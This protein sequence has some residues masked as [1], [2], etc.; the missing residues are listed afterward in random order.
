MKNSILLLLALF[1]VACGSPFE[2]PTF[3]TNGGIVRSN[4][5]EKFK[6]FVSN[7]IEVKSFDTTGIPGA[8]FEPLIVGISDYWLIGSGSYIAY[9]NQDKVEQLIQTEDTS[10]AA[11]RPAADMNKNIYFVTLKG[12]IY[13]YSVDGTKRFE[14]RFA[15]NI[16]E[17]ETFSD[18]LAT[19]DGVYFASSSGRFIKI[20]F[21][22]KIIYEKQFGASVSRSFSADFDDNVYLGITHNVFGE[23][24]T[25]A[26]LD[27]KGDLVFSKAID[28]VRLI[29]NPV[30]YD[31]IIYIAGQYQSGGVQGSLIAC[32]DKTGFERWR[33]ELPVFPR[34]ISVNRKGDLYVCGFNTG[35]GEGM[36][37]LFAY[38]RAGKQLWRL[39]ITATVSAPMIIGKK[40]I[41]IV[42]NTPNGAALFFL[43]KN[44][45]KMIADKALNEV[46]PFYS[47]PAVMG[48]GSLIFSINDRIGIIR[49]T[50]TAINKMLPW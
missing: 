9:I 1:F 7:L 38:N 20:N 24:D 6:E 49:V 2:E 43:D 26:M 35:V 12:N 28:F 5:Y 48:D 37:G 3:N 42:G 50:D 34:H 22:G 33:Q 30:V 18:V 19:K 10:L 44:N 15:G 8:N 23:T 16:S 46:P 27:S 13:S 14:L 17:F 11:S 45:G 32:Y 31:D 36:S 25:L 39:Y 40:K 21:E 29:R 4:S 41:A 47:V